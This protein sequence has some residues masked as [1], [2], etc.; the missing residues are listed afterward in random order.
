[1]QT[2]LITGIDGFTGNH[3]SHY[4]QKRD[5]EVFGTSIEQ[6][7]KNIFSCD[8]TKKE[9]I[10]QIFQKK[11]FDYIIHL[12]A[13][14]FVGYAD[15]VKMYEVN[16]FGVQNLLSALEEQAWTAKKVIIT[17]SAT[18]YGM[19]S[20][21]KLH[22]KLCPNP[23]N[24][25]A[26]SKYISEQIAKTYFDKIPIIITRPFNYTGC[27]QR[28]EFI[29]PK[30]VRAFQR[31]D[32]IIEIGNLHTKREMNDVIFVCNVYEKLLQSD[33]KSEIVN[34]CSGK[35]YDVA[36]FLNI[37]EKISGYTP[38]VRQNPKFIRSNDIEVLCGD[39]SKLHSLI[40]KIEPKPIE[41]T[42][43]EMYENCR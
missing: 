38:T 20:T 6:N 39:P 15:Q 21:N 22:E 42:I 35:V 23:N 28:E 16:A 9:Q 27:G 2:A 33:A 11:S 29:V 37:L 26:Y 10:R 13:I 40:G 17:S 24:H 32:S 4:L 1:M 41:Q 30:L 18:V 34:I 43:K 19:Q 31:K 25:Y 5:Y 12:A 14:S 8:I 3:L 7:G 36:Y